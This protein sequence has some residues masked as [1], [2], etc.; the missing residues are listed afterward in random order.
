MPT[1]SLPYAVPDRSSAVSV[2]FV[3]QRTYIEPH[4]LE[5][6]CDGVTPSF[7]DHRGGADFA[8]VRAALDAAE[9]DVVV[10]FRPDTVPAGALADL[11]APVLGV[12]TEPLPRAGRSSHV[13]LD[14]NLAALARTDR[15]NVDRVL[16]TDPLGW[17]AAA[18]HLPVWRCAPLPVADSL[19]RE[20]TPSRHPPRMMFLG[21]STMHRELALIDQKHH[22]DLAHYAHAL[23]GE[24]LREALAASDVA[25]CLH[26]DTGIVTFPSTLLLHLA[27]GHLVLSEPVD[28]DFGLDPG[29]HYVRVANRYELDLRV[30]QL[31]QM[32]DAYDRVRLRG[33][34]FA[35]QFRASRVWP[36]LVRDLLDDLQAFGTERTLTAA[37]PPRLGGLPDAV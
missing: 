27:A 16:L 22:F 30:H 10:V 37:E 11:S 23:L 32:P 9:P 4:V 34:H 33:N 25:I 21:H 28:P 18:E 13:S 15:A 17:E 5:G 3:G 1:L 8:P 26:N 6:A 29:V 14:F 31:Q 35:Q 36:R 12:A 2:A 19:Y 20:P 7:F 24:E